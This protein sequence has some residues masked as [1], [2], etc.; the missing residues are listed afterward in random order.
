MNIQVLNS[1]AHLYR[2]PLILEGLLWSIRVRHRVKE[3]IFFNAL[4]RLA[5]MVPFLSESQYSKC[6]S[7]KV[8]SGESL[9]EMFLWCMYMRNLV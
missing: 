6:M 4:L 8:V 5:F 1:L 2:V 3:M 9:L 7:Y